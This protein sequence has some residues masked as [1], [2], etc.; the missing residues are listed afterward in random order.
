MFLL[1]VYKELI[2]TSD[3]DC[4]FLY[5]FQ[6]IRNTSQEDVKNKLMTEIFLVLSKLITLSDNVKVIFFF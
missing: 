6:I 2:F 4:F 1:Y 3:F 5:I